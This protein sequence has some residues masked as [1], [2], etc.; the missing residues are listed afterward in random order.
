VA[1]Q[2]LEERMKEVRGD[3]LGDSART[4]YVGR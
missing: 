1:N 3:V 4:S 2:V